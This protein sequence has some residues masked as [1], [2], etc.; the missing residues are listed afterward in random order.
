MVFL[1]TD[2][3]ELRGFDSG[4]VL[5]ELARLSESRLRLT[6]QLLCQLWELA[7]AILADSGGDP[8]VADSILLSLQDGGDSTFP[9]AADSRPL[10]L[11]EN[12]QLIGELNSRSGLYGRLM[13]YRFLSLQRREQPELPLLPEADT[14]VGNRISYMKSALADKAYLRFSE[15]LPD[16]R[17]SEATSFVDACEE[18]YNGLCRFCLFPLEVSGEGRLTGFSRLIVKYGLIVAAA[19]D[20]ESQTP[21]GRTVTRFG[22]LC[23]GAGD[24]LPRCVLPSVPV[25]YIELLHTT[26]ASPSVTDLM[27]AAVFCGLTPVRFDTLPFDAGEAGGLSSVSAVSDAG[28][29]AEAGY[30]ADEPEPLPDVPPVSLVLELSPEADLP[31]LVRF[32][33][34]EASEDIFMGAYGLV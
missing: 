26:A 1:H 10:V 2:V 11:P 23:R 6:E 28:D 5:T 4:L 3:P 7:G 13:L 16:C 21:R 27:N 9:D 25:R 24:S 8:D 30:S 34:L 22:L 29:T 18:V 17:F 33:S 19:C 20:V 32:F 31:T 14:P 15:V 12:R